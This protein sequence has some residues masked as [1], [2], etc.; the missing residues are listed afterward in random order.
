VSTRKVVT[1][2]VVAGAILA[3]T[4]GIAMAVTKDGGSGDTTLRGGSGDDTL[5]GYARAD[6]LEGDSESDRIFAGS[7]R[8]DIYAGSSGDTIYAD[9]GYRDY[10]GCGSGFDRVQGDN[11]DRVVDC[12]QRS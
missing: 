9:D 10:I 6:S 4:A 8:D 1:L 3:L 2:F 7:G 5:Y 12:E 11:F